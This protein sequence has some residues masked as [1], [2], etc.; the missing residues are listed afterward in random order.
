MVIAETTLLAPYIY[1]KPMQLI[2]GYSLW[3]DCSSLA[4]WVAVYKP[5]GAPFTNVE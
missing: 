2:S 5:P 3:M 1:V 4:T